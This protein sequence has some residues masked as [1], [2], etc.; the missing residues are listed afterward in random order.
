MSKTPSSDPCIFYGRG[1]AGN[2][3]RRSSITS[4][5]SKI[6]S[7]ASSNP[8][9]LVLT[10]SPETH[11]AN[12]KSERRVSSS[13]SSSSSLARSAEREAG[14]EGRRRASSLGSVGEGGKGG[15]RGLFL[16]GRGRGAGRKE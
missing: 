16:R 14:G 6:A 3:R 4:A 11:Y 12:S 15:F 7:Q 5:W 13:A 9:K 2:M 1:G 10:S 8:T